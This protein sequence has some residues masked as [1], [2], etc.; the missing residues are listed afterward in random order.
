MK[1]KSKKSINSLKKQKVDAKKV[2]GGNIA[3]GHLDG[4]SV[5][6]LHSGSAH[7]VSAA[8][9]NSAS[10]GHFSSKPGLRGRRGRGNIGGF[11]IPL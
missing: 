8:D 4:A 2:K 9:S 11:P 7:N 5:D 10:A 1:T 3:A 6:E